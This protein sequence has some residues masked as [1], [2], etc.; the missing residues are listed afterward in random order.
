MSINFIGSYSGIDNSSIQQLMEVEKLPLAGL[1]K[2]KTSITEMQNAWKDINTRLKSLFDKVKVLQSPDI[3]QSKSAT[4]SNDAV[5]AVSAGKSAASSQYRIHVETLAT[6]SKSVGSQIEVENTTSALETE[7]SFKL[8]NADGKELQIE[9]GIDDSLKTVMDKINE[10]TNETGL[11]ASIIDK[12]LVIED[13]KTG[14]R[15]IQIEDVEG[16]ASV[17]EDLGMGSARVDS[18]GTNAE[19][20]INGIDVTRSS[21]TITDVVDGVTFNL[22]NTSEPGKSETITIDFDMAKAEKAIKDFVDQYNSTMTFIEDKMAAGT[23]GEPATRGILAGDG[24][25][26]RLHNSLRQ[27]VTSTI[28]NSDNTAIKDISALGVKTTDRFGKLTFDPSKLREELTKDTL[29]V[30]NFFSSTIGDNSVGFAVRINKYVDSFI[31]SNNG[32]IKGKTESFE[33]SIKDLNKQIDSFNK[34]VERKEQ[35]YI[36]MFSALDV[37][38]LQAEGQMQWLN[39]QISAMNAQSSGIKR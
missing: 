35:Y 31:S 15:E 4:S 3:F 13:T 23:P 28:S 30:K 22:K 7:G 26:Q 24:S 25:L 2:K 39:G 17:L 20:S 27:M 12:R 8:T 19:F 32:V 38:M 33:R 18:T 5:V 29:N 16:K 9:I 34:R 11:K 21:N 14:S 36:K 1:A 37:A 6:A 10:G